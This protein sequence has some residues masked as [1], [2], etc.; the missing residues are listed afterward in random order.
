MVLATSDGLH[1]LNAKMQVKHLFPS[2][3]AILNIRHADKALKTQK[4]AHASQ[5]KPSEELLA[6]ELGLIDGT[7]TNEAAAL[8]LLE[9]FGA[10][11]EDALLLPLPDKQKVPTPDGIGVS[12]L[13]KSW[14]QRCK[15][16]EEATNDVRTAY[17][18]AIK[19]RLGVGNLDVQKRLYEECV[20]AIRVG[21]AGFR[22]VRQLHL[23]P[24]A[25]FT[26]DPA[27]PITRKARSTVSQRPRPPP[28][29]ALAGLLVGVGDDHKG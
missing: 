17:Q 2:R 15:D 18:E 10:S 3:H 20:S 23:W 24:N 8:R 12:P 22:K 26:L 5:R 7:V 13:E 19:E 9:L 14:E 25:C 27:L 16:L 29:P 4:T 1:L 21:N 11:L 6:L 28:S